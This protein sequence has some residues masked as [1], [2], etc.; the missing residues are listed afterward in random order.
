MKP[1]AVA[2]ILAC[3]TWILSVAPASEPASSK[4]K[5]ESELLEIHLR[6][7]EAHRKTDLEALLAHAQDGF[8]YVRNG[9]ISRTNTS[10]MRENMRKYFKD[11]TYHVYE[12]LES[13]IIRASEDGKM[14]WIICRTHARRSQ[15]DSATGK[16]NLEEFV[17]AGI[18]TYELRDGK[19]YQVANVSTFEPTGQ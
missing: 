15:K 8:I 16:V 10:D 11:V 9:A 13:P 3:L 4:Q 17:Y 2:I 12:D 14:G 1:I 19:W 7:Y 18:T 6:G 5:A